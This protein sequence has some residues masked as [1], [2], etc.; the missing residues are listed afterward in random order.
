MEDPSQVP[1]ETDGLL[2][3]EKGLTKGAQGGDPTPSEGEQVA[4]AREG[5]PENAGEKG[6]MYHNMKHAF[7]GPQSD[8]PRECVTWTVIAAVLSCLA[9]A[10]FFIWVDVLYMSIPLVCFGCALGIFYYVYVKY[11]KKDAEQEEISAEDQPFMVPGM[12]ADD[13]RRDHEIDQ[14]FDLEN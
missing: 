13:I 4:G 5:E 10:I 1:E 14:E 7:A 8:D 2:N 9:L 6:F 3:K 11:G 12:G